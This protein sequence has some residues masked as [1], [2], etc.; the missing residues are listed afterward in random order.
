MY[1]PSSFLCGRNVWSRNMKMGG[2]YFI[3]FICLYKYKNKKD[4]MILDSLKGEI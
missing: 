2:L 1:F 4:Y 3:Y